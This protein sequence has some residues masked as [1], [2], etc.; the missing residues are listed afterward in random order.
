MARGYIDLEGL[1]TMDGGRLNA[2]FAMEVEKVYAD[3]DD[4]PAVKA[5]RRITLTILCKPVQDEAGRLDMVD[6]DWDLDSKLPKRKSRTYR[7]RHDGKGLTVSLFAPEHPGQRT[8]DDAMDHGE[9]S[10]AG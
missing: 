5:A 6:V 4:R 10:N 9:E 1:S 7:A 8:I 3:C 2:A